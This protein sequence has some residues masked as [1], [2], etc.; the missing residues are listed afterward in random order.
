[1]YTICLRMSV[2]LDANSFAYHYKKF[3]VDMEH[4]ASDL[5]LQNYV[6]IPKY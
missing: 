2:I 6:Q 1:M 4:L 5:V 3:Y